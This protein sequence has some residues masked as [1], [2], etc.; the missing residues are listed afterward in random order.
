MSA[1]LSYRPDSNPPA[2]IAEL[3]I[4]E[5]SSLSRIANHWCEPFFFL[6]RPDETLFGNTKVSL[7]GF[8]APDGSYV[9]VEPADD[10]FMMAQE[11]ELLLRC[12]SGWAKAYKLAWTIEFEGALVGR[13][14]N[15]GT[16]S[17]DLR[18]F[19]SELHTAAETPRDPEALKSRVSTL[20]AKYAQRAQ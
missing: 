13:V 12:I 11:V 6:R 1:S 7:P 20:R 2:H 16:Y 4:K 3:I 14:S 8:T 17:D 15:S 10:M 18:A 9:A 19:L 5:A